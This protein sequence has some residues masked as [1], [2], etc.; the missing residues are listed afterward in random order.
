MRGSEWIGLYAIWAEAEAEAA[1]SKGDRSRSQKL[2]RKICSMSGRLA[3]VVAQ[4]EVLNSNY[5]DK[6]FAPS[7]VAIACRALYIL[8]I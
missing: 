4:P 2:Q 3:K 1:A 7:L 6:I 5:G 8:Y